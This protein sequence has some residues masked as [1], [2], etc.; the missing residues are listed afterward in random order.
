M[1]NNPPVRPE[2]AIYDA[3]GTRLDTAGPVTVS[4]GQTITLRHT[5]RDFETADAQIPFGAFVLNA[6]DGRSV[7]VNAAATMDPHVG[8]T[9]Y[10]AA[11]PMGT[12]DVLN[13]RR[14]WTIPATISALP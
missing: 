12:G 3:N 6:P 9:Q 7:V 2:I 8:Q 14:T 13:F 4:A 10:D 11:G 1:L 5:V